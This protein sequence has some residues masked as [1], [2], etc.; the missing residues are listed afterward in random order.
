MSTYK[1]TNDYIFGRIFGQKK[2]SE[3]LK[4]LLEAILPDI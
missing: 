2:N 1:P 3:L 4:D